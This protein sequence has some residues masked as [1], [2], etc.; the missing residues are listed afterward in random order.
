MTH[1]AH[2]L[3]H[4]LPVNKSQLQIRWR[5]IQTVRL[6][7]IQHATHVQQG[8][9]RNI[10]LRGVAGGAQ[11]SGDWAQMRIGLSSAAWFAS[12]EQHESAEFHGCSNEIGAWDVD[13]IELKNKWGGDQQL[14]VADAYL[15]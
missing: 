7:K 8:S 10:D 14:C 15:A 6:N 4:P 1:V 12:S 2:T 5:I 9:C 3:A 11:R 13:T